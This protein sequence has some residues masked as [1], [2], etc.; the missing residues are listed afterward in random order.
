MTK[1]AIYSRVSTDDQTVENQ[2]MVLREIASR[3]GMTVVAEFNDEGISGAKGRDKR[4]GFDNIIKGAVK[5]DYD[6]ILV[7]S[8]D[9]LGRSLQD[10]VS[11]LNEVHSVDCDLYIHQSGIDT[12]TPTGKMMF[13][14][15]GVFSEFERGMIRE[16]VV[17]GQK[18]AKNQGKHIGR[19]TNLNEG[20]V[21]SIKYMKE[22]GVGI[23]KIAKDLSVGVGTVYK[24]LEAA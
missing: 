4:T 10:L 19:P 21:H 12:S 16:R 14:M 7:W 17:A 6:T 11:F 24:V 3:K 5:K 23:R 20:L 2:L 9:R 13:Q 22:Q 1:C 15:C 18:R 8:V